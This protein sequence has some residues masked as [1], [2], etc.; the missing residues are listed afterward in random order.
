VRVER[1]D[2]SLFA[3]L[4]RYP[5]PGNVRELENVIQRAVIYCRDGVLSAQHL[6][7][8]VV[9]CQAGPSN[10]GTSLG[11]EPHDFIDARTRRG[12]RVAVSEREIIEEA[13]FKYNYSRTNTAKSLGISRVTL[14]NKMKKYGMSK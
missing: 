13:L 6:P 3:A 4:Y 9:M 11:S 12:Q 5:W 2:D 14:Y 1:I 8:H 10:D 7:P